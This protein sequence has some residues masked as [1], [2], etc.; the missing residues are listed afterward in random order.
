MTW[1]NHR[2]IHNI[3]GM[4]L[5]YHD[6]ALWTDEVLD[7]LE[8]SASRL[9]ERVTQEIMTWQAE[10]DEGTAGPIPPENVLH[11]SA[12]LEVDVAMAKAIILQHHKFTDYDVRADKE[13]YSPLANDEDDH[14]TVTMMNAMVNAVRKA[15]WADATMGI[16]RFGLPQDLLVAA[17]AA[18]LEAGFHNLLLNFRSRLSP[19]SLRGQL[20]VLKI[21]KW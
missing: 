1:R 3:L 9:Q 11:W 6:I 4:A 19:E 14:S 21:L 15:D 16:I 12:S 17:Y 13:L 7:Y 2:P 18:I 10:G 8:P 20:D 5:A